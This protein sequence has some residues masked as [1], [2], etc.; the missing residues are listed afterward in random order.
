MR[1]GKGIATTESWRDAARAD[2]QARAEHL[3]LP[4]GE[5][6][7]VLG[8]ASGHG[9]A[10]SAD[11]ALAKFAFR[12]LVRLYPDPAALLAQRHPAVA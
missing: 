9:I 3:T 8:D 4:G 12:S 6:A 7:G 10:A 1:K 2:R 5:L 11:M